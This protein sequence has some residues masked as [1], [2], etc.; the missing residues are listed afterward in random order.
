MPDF[1]QLFKASEPAIKTPLA[2]ETGDAEGMALGTYDDQELLD[3]WERLKRESFDSRWV[4]ERQWMR[5]I[6][7]ILGRQWI[8]YH[9]RHGGWKD[10]RMAAWIPRPV[11]N[12]CKETVQALRAVFTDIH[13]GVNVRPNGSDP[14]NVSAAAVADE[15]S[16]VLHESHSMDSVLS[17]FDFW[18]LATGN[19]FFHTFVDYDIKY[20]TIRDMMEQCVACQEITPS[21][22]LVGA[23]PV[24][25]SCGASEFQPALDDE[26]MPMVDEKPVGRPKTIPLSPLELAFPNSYPR[27]EELPYVVRMRWRTKA[28]FETHPKLKELVPTIVWQKSPQDQSLQIFKSLANHND[29]GISPS[30]WAE[31]GSPSLQEDGITEYEVWMK[32]ND[33]Y[34]EGLVF[35]VY[36]DSKPIVAH[37]EDTEELPG[38]LPYRDAD[39]KPLFTFTHAGYDHVGGRIL[40]SGPI[41]QIAQKQDQLNQLD[42]MILLII[43]RMANPVWL[44]PKG[45]EIE[46]L[47]GVPGLVIKWNPLTVGGQAKPERIPG[48]NPPASLFQIREQYLRDIEE[49]VGTYDIIKGAK[50][51]G[52]EAFSALQLLVERSQSR[53]SPIFQARGTAY[54]DWYKF[55][56]ELEREFGPEE[57]TKSVLSP[58]RTW[59]FQQF[60][61]TQLQGSISII[62]E[63][64]STV[65]KTNLGMRAAIEHASGLGMLNLQDPDQQY[66]GLKMF[67][68]TRLVPSLDIHVQRALQ[69]HQQFEEWLMDE[70]QLVQFVQNAEQDQL[71]YQEQAQVALAQPPQ[72][73]PMT[74]I[75]APP[76]LPPAPS[77]LEHTPL[78]WR[79]WYSPRVHKQEFEKWANSDRMIE[80]LAAKPF[81][82][83]LLEAH[84][85][86]INLA[87][88]EQEGMVPGESGAPVPQG[89]GMA[90]RNSNRESTQGV[91]PKGQSQGNQGAGPV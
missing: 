6:Y 40:A 51:T 25:P 65:P 68:L 24:C 30:Y 37:L 27:F 42:S 83:G 61:R 36:G 71:A 47:T 87:L 63:D 62:V 49:L 82:E 38:P 3:L 34:P 74:G 16:N 39:G 81:A 73:D 44:E 89:R 5:N 35:R 19:A 58:S 66:E 77:P 56:I 43:Q 2:K 79:P 60:K 10:K 17:E 59:T 26:G 1:N 55:A 84:Y 4:F 70:Q 20:G 32:P 52:I 75:A 28:Y 88:A 45:A 29:L 41:D 69:K 76:Q 33:A 22:K 13:L 85:A 53:F 46:R 78:K 18:L 91:E 57:R 31:S 8:E 12:K 23:T 9:A 11:T 48:E 86:E 15:L 72:V 7:Y 80:L 54:K 14:K 21:S 90:M 64:G 67:G 50:P